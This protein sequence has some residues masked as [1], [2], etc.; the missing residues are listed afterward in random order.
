MPVDTGCLECRSDFLYEFF[1]SVLVMG[2]S[3]PTPPFHTEITHTRV[4][5]YMFIIHVHKRMHA[6]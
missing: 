3:S 5:I 2:Q 6:Y 1:A 4:F